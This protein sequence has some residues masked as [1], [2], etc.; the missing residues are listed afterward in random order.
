ML[1]SMTFFLLKKENLV[2]L[3]KN[4]IIDVN[5]TNIVRVAPVI[6]VIKRSRPD[7]LY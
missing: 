3:L 1:T 7:C 4:R 5:E 6:N 2:Y